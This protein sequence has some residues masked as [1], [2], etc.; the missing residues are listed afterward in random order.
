MGVPLLLRDFNRR[1]VGMP[2]GY[3][4]PTAGR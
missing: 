3:T 4:V 1:R 2:I